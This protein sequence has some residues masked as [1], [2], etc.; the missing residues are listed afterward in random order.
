MSLWVT[1]DYTTIPKLSLLKK[2]W[3]YEI[4]EKLLGKIALT[5][6]APQPNFK[7]AIFVIYDEK[8]VKTLTENKINL[9]LLQVLLFVILI[10]MEPWAG[11][12]L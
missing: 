9:S 6:L 12:A 11:H 5:V 1:L 3:Q 8:I 7:I 4:Q 2:P 10:F